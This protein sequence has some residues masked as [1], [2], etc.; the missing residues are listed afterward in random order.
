ML[1]VSLLALA[2]FQTAEDSGPPSMMTVTVQKLPA[3]FKED[4]VVSVTFTA[5]GA[6]ASCKLAKTSGNASIDRVACAQMTSNAKVAPVPGKTPEPR[7][8]TVT[9]V[10]EA[11]KG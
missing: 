6:V 5:K 11:P 9:F 10:Q 4:P 7:D 2:S 1:L 8:A 3:N